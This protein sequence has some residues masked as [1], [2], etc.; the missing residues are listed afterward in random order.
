M[1]K[2]TVYLP[3]ELYDLAKAKLPPETSWSKVLAGRLEELLE[4]ECQH[5][6][7]VCKGCGKE[8]QNGNTDIHTSVAPGHEA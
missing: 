2:F 5:H 4:H 7:M 1:P 8:L 3:N 6:T